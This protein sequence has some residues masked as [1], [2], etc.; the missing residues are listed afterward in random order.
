M[1]A[2]DRRLFLQTAAAAAAAGSRSRILGANDRINLVVIG[3][4]GRG[5]SHVNNFSRIEGCKIVGV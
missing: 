5:A 4:G 3:I 2:Y 1:S